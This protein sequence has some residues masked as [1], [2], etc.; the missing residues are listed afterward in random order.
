MPFSAFRS[1]AT[2]WVT[3]LRR[4][5]SKERTGK[6]RISKGYQPRRATRPSARASWFPRPIRTSARARWADLKCVLSGWG[7]K[8]GVQ[9]RAVMRSAKSRSSSGRGTKFR[10]APRT[11]RTGGDGS[12][13]LLQVAAPPVPELVRV[14][15]EDPVG[16]EV[17]RRE[18]RHARDPLALAEIVAGLA[19][20]VEHAVAR[21]PLEDLGR[22]VLRPVVGG[23]DEVDTGREVVRDLRVDDVGLVAREKGHDEL[24]A[25]VEVSGAPG[26]D[27]AGGV[28]AGRRDAA[29]CSCEHEI[30]LRAGSGRRARPAPASPRARGRR[31]SP[32]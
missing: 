21:V 16:A 4:H 22:P 5:C 1:R 23:D 12:E 9:S 20:Q 27:T 25:A 11:A 8:L 6:W 19:D 18:A 3:Y 2:N 7:W 15:V 13:Q 10:Q 30:A 17:G 32:A 28:T 24:H 31:P 26:T 14:R 29:T